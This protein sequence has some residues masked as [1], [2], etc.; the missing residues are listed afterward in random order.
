MRRLPEKEALSSRSSDREK[1][2]TKWIDRSEQ[3]RVGQSKD[4]FS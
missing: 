4:R 1:T 2:K 3:S